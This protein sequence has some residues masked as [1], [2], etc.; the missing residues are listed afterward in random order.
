M[1]PDTLAASVMIPRTRADALQALHDFL[2]LA[3]DYAR[4]RNQV[5][6]PSH[7]NVSRLSFALRRRLITEDE[8]AAATLEAHPFAA[9]EKW[10]QEVWW[11][12]YWKGWLELRPG[13]WSSWLDSVDEDLTH[14]PSAVLKRARAV[15][16][17]RGGVAVMDGFT[18]ELI[19]TGYLHNHA[20]MWWAAYWTHT[21]G[22]PWMLGAAFFYRHLI[23]ADPASNTLSWRWVAGLQT[24][25][26]TYLARRSN[27][28]K[29]LSGPV[30]WSGA[31]RLDDD[32]ARPSQQWDPSETEVRPLADAATA[33]PAMAAPA[34]LW[35]H[36]DDLSVECAAE[37]RGFKPDKILLW[38]DGYLD[39]LLPPGEPA[40]DAAAGAIED[41]R[42]RL[43]AW[44]GAPVELSGGA[45]PATE[46]AFW[47]LKHELR[48]V[49]A[50]RPFCGPLGDLAASVEGTLRPLGI[51]MIWL[52]RAS[53]AKG[54]PRARRGFF[55]FW[56]G[57]R[58]R[59]GQEL[60]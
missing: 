46:I 16:E 42:Q 20:R 5:R 11:R 40:R 6:P 29:Y 2:P 34:G 48:F 30:D 14:H 55:P 18:R 27:L 50:M 17:G 41:A 26:K 57:A 10:L 54:L 25:G 59:G 19:R 15:C 24:P 38:Q 28:E 45:D 35:V 53:D 22:L 7:D 36:E 44:S 4:V 32:K 21:E 23:D 3:P 56:D 51:N 60:V 33:L 49:V 12:R 52:R 43:S 31:D 58:R 13:V 1:S 47:A 39:G 9:V 8:V 37:L